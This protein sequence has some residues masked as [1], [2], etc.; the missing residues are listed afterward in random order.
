M[1]DLLK[2][3]AEV[4]M[5]K[6]FDQVSLGQGQ[7]PQAEKL[8]T[9][10]RA[11]G[12]WVVLQN[13]H[14]AESWMPVLERICENISPD[15]TDSRFRLWLTSYPSDH[16]PVAVLQNGIKM[17]SDPPKGLRANLFQS[18]IS[19]PV[20]EP[21]FFEGCDRPAEFKKLLYGLCF[22]HAVIQERLKFG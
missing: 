22:F 9:S 21:E 19:D 11:E 6:R 13:C 4:K 18:Y 3:A 17:T 16:F 1:A 5:L 20:S 8:I 12:F 2:F 15:S 14:L 7:G 10:G